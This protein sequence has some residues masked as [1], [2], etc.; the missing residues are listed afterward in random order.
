ML[1]NIFHFKKTILKLKL[2]SSNSNLLCWT[3]ESLKFTLKGSVHTGGEVQNPWL[4]W[5]VPG[6]P[7]TQKWPTNLK[8]KKNLF[9]LISTQKLLMLSL[10]D[11]SLDKSAVF[12][13]VN[14]I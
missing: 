8:E 11:F 7:K 2:Y 3:I 4:Y 14:K 12:K 10:Q 5:L 1:L 13:V 9:A 6:I